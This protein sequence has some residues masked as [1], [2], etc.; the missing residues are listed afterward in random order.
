M[1][2]FI[3]QIAY[4]HLCKAKRPCVIITSFVGIYEKE[5]V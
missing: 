4:D 1:Y 3:Y 5:I 2:T